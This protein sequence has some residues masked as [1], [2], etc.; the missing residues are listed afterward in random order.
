MRLLPATVRIAWHFGVRTRRLQGSVLAGLLFVAFGW[1]WLGHGFTDTTDF[2]PVRNLS[3]TPR[4]LSLS[5][6]P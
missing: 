4:I 3:G 1:V 6:P 5:K 2:V